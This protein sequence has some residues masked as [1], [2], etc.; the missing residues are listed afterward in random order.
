MAVTVLNPE[1]L[2]KC[3]RAISKAFAEGNDEYAAYLCRERKNFID[4]G[5]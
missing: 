3:D 5:Y 2:E 1:K 4:Y